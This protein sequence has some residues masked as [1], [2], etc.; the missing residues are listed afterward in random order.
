MKRDPEDEYFMLAVLAHKMIH[1]ED[2][3]EFDYIFEVD[4]RTLLEKVKELGMP[5]HRWYKWIEKHF[6][7]LRQTTFAKPPVPEGKE[8][9]EVKESKKEG[10]I[11]NAFSKFLSKRRPKHKESKQQQPPA[12]ELETFD[13]NTP[14][15]RSST[16]VTSKNML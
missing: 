15:R 11:L 13:E 14:F 4:P 8:G 5:Y 3:A 7:E 9:K 6:E 10:G 2:H 12:K 1:T 16:Y